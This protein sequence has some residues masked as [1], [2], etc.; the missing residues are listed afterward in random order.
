MWSV[1]CAYTFPN[2]QIREACNRLQDHSI[3]GRH[4]HDDKLKG[5][6]LGML[7]TINSLSIIL[8][9]SSPI[10]KTGL[11]KKETNCVLKK[12]I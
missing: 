4:L 9:V 3:S 2:K 7:V 1:W 6:R 11:I 12:S 8:R 10:N 5:D